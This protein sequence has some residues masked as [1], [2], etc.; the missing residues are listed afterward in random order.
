MDTILK[1]EDPNGFLFPFYVQQMIAVSEHTGGL[2]TTLMKIHTIHESKVNEITEN[3]ATLLEPMLMIL[4][5]GV[6]LF[7]AV[8]ILSPIYGL[9]GGISDLT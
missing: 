7:L 8:A 4:I 2:T 5:F 1:T 6:V 9:I 3:L